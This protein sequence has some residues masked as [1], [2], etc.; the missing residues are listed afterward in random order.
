MRIPASSSFQARSS[1]DIA[2]IAVRRL[3]AASAIVGWTAGCRGPANEYAPPPPPEVTVTAAVV[4]PLTEFIEENGQTEATQRAE[5]RARVRGFVEAIEFD[6]GQKVDRETTLYRIEDDEYRAAVQSAEAELASADAS[7]AVAQADVKTAEAEA[8]RSGRE[9]AR[10]D[11][12]LAQ[13]ATSQSDYDRAVAANG[14]AQANLAAAGSAVEAA[15]A[16]REQAAAKLAQAELDLAYTEVKAP[17]GGRVT[18]TEVKLGNLVDVGTEL[19]AVVDDTRVYANFSISDRE[20]LAFQE[21]VGEAPESPSGEQRWR[22]ATVFLQRESDAGFPF[23]G[24]LDYVDQEGVDAA[25]GTLSLRAAFDNEDGSLFPGLFVRVRVPTRTRPAA[26]LIPAG[27]VLRDRVGPH[28]MLIGEQNRVT[29]RDVRLGQQ[30]EGWVVIEEG[31]E[32]GEKFVVEGLQRA[33][34]GAPVDPIDRPATSA[35]LPP[36]FRNGSATDGSPSESEM[37]AED[38]SPVTPDD[39]S[40]DA[41]AAL[42][43]TDQPTR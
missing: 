25:T 5:V 8:D 24:R 23:V 19:A 28:L 42:P 1:F 32:A 10:Q 40:A 14:A 21:A 13:Q 41:D 30:A 22:K 9:L 29:R 37:T 17:I 33:R 39:A 16:R 15:Q 2:V 4:H 27:A 35:D 31:L 6:P 26:L 43:A 36:A 11:T 18:K 3:V 12:L 7:I 38:V 20:M 34:P